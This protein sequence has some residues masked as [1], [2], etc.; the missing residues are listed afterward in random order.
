MNRPL[1]LAAAC[2][3][4]VVGL[5]STGCALRKPG[6]ARLPELGIEHGS[7]RI[8]APVDTDGSIL[9]TQ[10]VQLLGHIDAAPI[11]ASEG[12]S[13]ETVQVLLHDGCY[14]IA[15][16]GFGNV[17]R[18]EPEAGTAR[19][20]YRAIP[21]PDPAAGPVR[22][23]RWGA[24]DRSCVRLDAEHGGPWFVRSTGE[25]VDACG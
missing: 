3:A 18:V 17:W 4:V 20:T 13:A 12:A 16:E 7:F 10:R 15:A 24:S 9:L 22:L 8:E 2:L 21:L 6:E 14:W 19:A 11:F 23:S 5:A 25:I 1:R